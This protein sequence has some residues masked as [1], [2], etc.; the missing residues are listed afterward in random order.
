MKMRLVTSSIVLYVPC[1]YVAGDCGAEVRVHALGA[2]VAGHDPHVQQ[3]L[4]LLHQV[5]A[6]GVALR[7]RRAVVG[8][9]RCVDARGRRLDADVGARAEQRT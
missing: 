9:E 3:V 5:A 4:R 7:L 8:A 1:R 6:D 2:L